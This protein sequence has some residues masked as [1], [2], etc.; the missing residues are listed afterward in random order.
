VRRGRRRASGV[1][2]GACGRG[3][4]VTPARGGGR[5]GWNGAGGGDGEGSVH[6]PSSGTS[7]WETAGWRS[8]GARCRVWRG[9]SRGA[10]ASCP[11]AL[12]SKGGRGAREEA[13]IGAAVAGGGGG[14]AWRRGGVRTAAAQE[15]GRRRR[16]RRVVRR[17]EE[18]LLGRSPGGPLGA[19]RVCGKGDALGGAALGAERGAPRPPE[20]L[21]RG[22]AVGGVVVLEPAQPRPL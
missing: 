11:R 17:V 15:G 21:Q 16:R 12:R 19:K 14:R 2:D 4:H 1:V 5:G 8:E 20:R 18:R 22:R 10:R 3:G 13:G 7:A 6:Q 9:R